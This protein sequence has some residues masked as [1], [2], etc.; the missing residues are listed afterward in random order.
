MQLGWAGVSTLP[1]DSSAKAAFAILD[2]EF[3]AGVLSP[4]RVMVDSAELGSPAVQSGV[5]N[6]VERLTADNDFGPATV[7]T[8]EAG[9]LALIERRLSATRRRAARRPAPLRED[10]VPAHSVRAREV[11]VGGI[12]PWHR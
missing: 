1:S 9:D 4:A 12:L 3:S 7:S 11:L 8:N 10:Y 6:L 5:T 2:D